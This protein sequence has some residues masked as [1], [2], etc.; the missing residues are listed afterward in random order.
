MTDTGFNNQESIGGEG[1]D[2]EINETLIVRKF[3]RGSCTKTVVVVW[4]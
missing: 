3:N 4:N 2:V 1:V